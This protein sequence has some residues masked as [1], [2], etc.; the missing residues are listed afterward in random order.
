[1]SDIPDLEEVLVGLNRQ[2]GWA[3]PEARF[4][5]VGTNSGRRSTFY[6]VSSDP[7]DG[8]D[9][10]VKSGRDEWESVTADEVANAMRETAATVEAAELSGV[11]ALVPLAWA[12]SPKIVVSRYID[13]VDLSKVMRDPEHP[14]WEGRPG[15]M[16]EWLGRAGAALAA[17]HANSTIGESAYADSVRSFSG[18]TTRLLVRPRTARRLLPGPVEGLHVRSYV[19]PNPS[20]WRRGVDGTVWLL[21]PPIEAR[22]AFVHRDVAHFLTKAER[23]L[24]IPGQAWRFPRIREAFLGGYG[25]IGPSLRGPRDDAVVELFRARFYLGAARG[26]SRRRAMSTT[27][28]SLAIAWQ[29]RRRAVHHSGSRQP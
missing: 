22:F 26:A 27:G 15:I 13:G 4:S 5:L 3:D 9:L 24:R 20:N 29:V 10:V 1:M 18:A 12:D 17:Y 8:V 23:L 7:G 25:S 21:D 14:L 11:R 6:L 28:R 2:F 19:D 16:E